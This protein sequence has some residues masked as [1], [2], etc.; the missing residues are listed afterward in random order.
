MEC[1]LPVVEEQREDLSDLDFGSETMRT[2]E[3]A[4]CVEDVPSARKFF[5]NV[6]APH[7]LPDN[8]PATFQVTVRGTA[9]RIPDSHFCQ[10]SQDPIDCSCFCCALLN[11]KP[12]PKLEYAVQVIE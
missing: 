12:Y 9:Y 3:T 11:S 6:G 10:R 4:S 7:P 8:V 1:L 2:R 5:E